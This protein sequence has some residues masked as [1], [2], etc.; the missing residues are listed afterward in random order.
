MKK[1]KMPNRE[2]PPTATDC[3]RFVLSH[4]TVDVA[5]TGIQK[6]AELISNLKTFELGP[7]SPE[8]ME[9]MRRVGDHVYGR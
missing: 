1:K 7:M 5:I 2:D 9:R 4:P 8:E 3:Y 6:G